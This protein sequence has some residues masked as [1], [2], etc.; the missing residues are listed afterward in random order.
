MPKSRRCRFRPTPGSLEFVAWTRDINY[1]SQSP[2]KSL[3]AFYL[4]EMAS[5]GWEHDESAAAIENDS[6]KLTFKHDGVEGQAGLAAVVEG[7]ATSDLDCENL[8]FNGTDDPAKLA[9]A[10]I[11]VPRAVLF[12]QKELPL[13]AGA[14]NVRIHGRGLHV[15]VVPEAAGGL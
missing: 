15:Q 1:K 7:S 14:V 3:A 5:R 12:L 2:L 9:A 4:K 8:K 10:G 11:P 6:I 13:P